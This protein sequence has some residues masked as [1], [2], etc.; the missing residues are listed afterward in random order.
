Q[1]LANPLTVEALTALILAILLL[2]VRRKGG[3]AGTCVKCGR[4]FCPR[5]KSS[6]E[7]ATYCTQC[8]HIYLKRDGVSLDTKKRKMEE[9]QGY[10][11][12]TVRNRKLLTTLLPGTASLLAGSP[13]AGFLIL[14]AFLL[15]VMIALLT[16]RLAPIATPADT[17][18]LVLRITAIVL[19]VAVWLATSIPVY[20]QRATG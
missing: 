6:R 9:V 2:M 11:A 7:S 3:M 17:M 20:R 14:V 1:S 4:T 12:S 8:I 13:W 16:G 10:Q 15:F 5:C 19:A 18:Q